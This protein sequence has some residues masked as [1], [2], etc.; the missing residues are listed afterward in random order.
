MR[1]ILAAVVAVVALVGACAPSQPPPPLTGVRSVSDVLALRALHN[2]IPFCVARF[3][4]DI[5]LTSPMTALVAGHTTVTGQGPDA[6][7]C[8]PRAWVVAASVT[9][10][11]DCGVVGA[12][13]RF[14]EQTLTTLRFTRRPDFAYLRVRF[15][16]TYAGVQAGPIDDPSPQIRCLLSTCLFQLASPN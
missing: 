4:G 11:P 2:F 8:D 12:G 10:E 1:R 7:L 3:Y 13:T 14:M 5:T 6:A 16:G 15:L 9:C